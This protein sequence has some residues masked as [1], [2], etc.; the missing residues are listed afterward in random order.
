M[1]SAAARVEQPTLFKRMP[2]S[3]LSSIRTSTQNYETV[4]LF[5][6][7]FSLLTSQNIQ[8]FAQMGLRYGKSRNIIHFLL[9]QN[10]FDGIGGD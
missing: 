5:T 2:P 4:A 8:N 6:P 1:H 3:S 7:I 10:S 9:N